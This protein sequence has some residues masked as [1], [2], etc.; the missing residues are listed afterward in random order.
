[1]KKIVLLSII[2]VFVYVSVQAQYT[3][4]R[5]N[6]KYE[7][8]TDSLKNI[9]Y[10]YFFPILGQGAYSEGFDIP[11]PAGIMANYMWM[12]QSIVID[13][14]QLGLKTNNLD[15]PLTGVDFIDFGKN[16]NTSYTANVRPDLW[17]F[18]FLNVYGIFGYGQSSTEVNLLAPIE[19]KSVVDQGVSTAGVGVMTAFG[20]GPVW[21]SADF[22]WTWNKPE[23]LDK[24]VQVNVMGLRIGHT[25][26]FR[27]HPTRNIAVWVGG[28]RA[29]MGTETKG[30]VTLA[31]ALPQDVW[32]RK[33][34]IVDN[35]WEWYDG[36]DPNNIV[37]RKK[38]EIADEV[39]TPIVN[40]I[41]AAD[42][43]A[44]IRYGMDKQVKQMWNGIIG[45]QFQLN[46]SWM[47]R[48]E[49]GL[50]GDRKSL[51]FSVNYRFRI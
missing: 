11:Y 42:G 38:I 44:E 24:A 26:T 4:T 17:I 40:R 31:D 20:V 27:D 48:T 23:L 3:T 8:Y 21:V 7:A 34:E 33:D 19:L 43:S 39:L 13:N 22:N 15:I 2:I 36:L 16:T 46:K 35:Y 47:F 14:M 6:S 45:M 18:P 29:K 51:L 28:M 10:D 1:M 5:I 9:E 41:D 32:D 37:D 12:R 25:F 49:G 50:I 30:A